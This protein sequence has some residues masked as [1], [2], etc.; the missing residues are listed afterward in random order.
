MKVN[1][2]NAKVDQFKEVFMKKTDEIAKTLKEGKLEDVASEL[3]DT[4]TEATGKIDEFVKENPK[5]AIALTALGGLAAG[6]LV[7][8]KRDSIED[9]IGK[10]KQNASEQ[11]D[12]LRGQVDK[13]FNK[14]R[15]QLPGLMAGLVL[16]LVADRILADRILQGKS[17]KQ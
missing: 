2:V 17:D 7:G 11:F 13:T 6:Y 5:E 12:V 14:V 15:E 9:G 16:G 3:K 8:K 10:I 4:V 1:D